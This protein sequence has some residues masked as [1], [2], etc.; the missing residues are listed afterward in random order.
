MWE[1][2]RDAILPGVRIMPLRICR[3]KPQY[4]RPLSAPRKTCRNVISRLIRPQLKTIHQASVFDKGRWELF[5][6]KKAGS[7][8][9]QDSIGVVFCEGLYHASIWTSTMLWAREYGTGNWKT[10]FKRGGDE[11]RGIRE[12]RVSMTKNVASKRIT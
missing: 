11:T 9:E 2:Q 6:W 12:L 5:P 1:T 4:C 8:W 10:P 3:G 7:C